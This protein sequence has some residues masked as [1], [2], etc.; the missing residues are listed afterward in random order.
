M[1]P[2]P[3]PTFTASAPASIRAL[4]A[5]ASRHV[6]CD[7]LQI[8]ISFLDHLHAAKNVRRMAVSGVQNHYIHM[9]L[10]QSI[11]TLQHIGGDANCCAAEQTSLSVLGRLTDI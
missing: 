9:C 2:G 5:S 1:E 8:R 3:I 11:Y 4:V 6:S 10:Y 7:H